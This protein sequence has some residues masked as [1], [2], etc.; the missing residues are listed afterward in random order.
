M[1]E[2]IAETVQCLAARPLAWTAWA[3]VAGVATGSALARAGGWTVTLAA[4]AV[5]V[6]AVSMCFG[7]R[8][9]LGAVCAAGFLV[10]VARARLA[11]PAQLDAPRLLVVAGMPH[12]TASGGW[13]V[14]CVAPETRRPVQL[15]GRGP[16]PSVSPGAVLRGRWR[17]V[18]PARPGERGLVK[19]HDASELVVLRGAWPARSLAAVRARIR[20]RLRVALHREEAAL[21]EDLALGDR[22][23]RRCSRLR[24]AFADAGVAHLLAISGLHLAWAAALVAW[25]VRALLG[26]FRVPTSMGT[27]W[28]AARLAAGLAALGVWGW[29]GGA[30]PTR[31]A[32]LMVAVWAA[33]PPGT[34]RRDGP[35]LVALAAAATAL[36]G[37]R[38]VATASWQLSFAAVAALVA[39]GAPARDRAP[40]AWLRAALRAACAAHLATAPVVAYHFGAVPLGAPLVNALAVPAFGL[41]LMPA[42]LLGAVGAAVLPAAWSHALLAGPVRL[43]AAGFIELVDAIRWLGWCVPVSAP[44]AWAAGLA[45]AAGVAAAARGVGLPGR[46]AALAAWAGLWAAVPFAL[47]RAA[48]EVAV[49]DV[50]HGLAVAVRLPDG[51]GAVVDAGG[52]AAA[53]SAPAHTRLLPALARLGVRRLDAIVA[54]HGDVDHAGGLGAVLAARPAGVFLVPALEREPAVLAAAV[55]TAAASGVRVVRVRRDL[56]VTAG[57]DARLVVLAAPTTRRLSANDAALVVRF[58]AEGHSVLVAGDIEAT[59]EAALV[60]RHAPLQADAVVVPHHGSA[61]SST[62]VFVRAVGARWC[63]VSAHEGVHPGIPSPTVLERWQ[64]AGCAVHRTDREGTLV[65]RSAR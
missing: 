14:A 13:V 1:R 44:P 21:I 5:V 40:G 29:T 60:A 59:R 12:W 49:A 65:W 28:Y 46:L 57:P 55:A 25:A 38:D 37:P 8:A 33:L 3:T 9:A 53:P 6:A 54:T 48:L 31:R 22:A 39:S 26:C 36:A 20:S 30:V 64:R 18:G 10:G 51:T 4:A 23:T 45:V 41:L 63:A 42:V 61:T 52:V 34:G 62:P 32:A 15:A 27:T 56:R 11:A 43:A 16:S 7:P 2:H 17:L 35:T 19:V 24:D 47:P 58:E 50:G